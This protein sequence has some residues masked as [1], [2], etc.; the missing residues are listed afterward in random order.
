MSV[1]QR[2]VGNLTCRLVGPE[3]PGQP[4]QACVILCHGYGAGGDDLVP[5]AGE[6]RRL[7]PQLGER[8][9]FVFPQ[10]PLSMEE[11]PGGRA[12][13]PIDL[14]ALQLA[15]ERGELRQLR[16]ECPPRLPQA[17]KEV[18]GLIEKLQEETGLSLSRFILGGFSQG[19]MLAT[20]VALRLDESI[21]GLLIYSG[22]LLVEPEWRELASHRRGLR[23]LQS[24]GTSDTLLPFEAATW[25][26]D[27]LESAG[28]QVQFLPF[29]GMHTIPAEAVVA[30]AR[31]LSEIVEKSSAGDAV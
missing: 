10:G 3:S 21:G 4:P 16:Q 9:L 11:V 13:W 2:T 20:D 22:T 12:W 27:L 7:N 15:G 8:V 5:L 19:S 28:A 18:M 31:L 1:E 17:R 29:P 23:V 26:R 30:S 14:A 24:H 25:L 6:L